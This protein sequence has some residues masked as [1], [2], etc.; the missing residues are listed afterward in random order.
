[1]GDLTQTESRPTEAELLWMHET[2]CRG[3]LEHRMAPHAVYPDPACPHAGCKQQLQGIDFRIEE[4][5]PPLHDALLR[6]WWTDVGFAGRCP[7]C[8]RWVHFSIRAK[9]AITEEEARLL[10]QLPDGWADHAFIL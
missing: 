7:G 8:G 3:S 9:R 2:Y 5:G 10:P 4:H 1:M 6:A